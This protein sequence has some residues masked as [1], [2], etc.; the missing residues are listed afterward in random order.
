[1]SDAVHAGKA[2]VFRVML[3]EAGWTVREEGGDA[4]SH[5]SRREAVREAQR[6]AQAK[7]VA[8]VIVHY[9]DSSVERQ[10][11]YHGEPRSARTWRAGEIQRSGSRST[12]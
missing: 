12:E 9:A 3:G 5:T 2:S 6:R 1:M 7:D 4:T 10:I 8:R 11:L